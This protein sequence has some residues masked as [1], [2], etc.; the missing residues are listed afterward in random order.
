V[1]L[2]HSF[3]TQADKG[4]HLEILRRG[5]GVRC[6]PIFSE[7][8][9]GQVQRLLLNEIEAGCKPGS[10]PGRTGRWNKAPAA[11][12]GSCVVWA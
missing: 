1:K 3:L 6:I 11:F 9:L 5:G 7:S 2:W 8:L 10:W 12:T 4:T